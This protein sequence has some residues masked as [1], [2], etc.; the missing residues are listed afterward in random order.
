MLLPLLLCWLLL[1]RPHIFRVI[2]RRYRISQ[3]LP[4]PRRSQRKPE[5]V[6]QEVLRLA[7]PPGAGCRT[8]G[9]LFNRCYAHS[10]KMTVSKSYVHYTLCRH[11]Y[12]IEVM[13]RQLKHRP[14]RPVP[15]NRIWG[16]DLTGKGDVFGGIHQIL[17]VVDH[18]SRRLLMLDAV[19]HKNAWILLGQLFIAIGCFGKPRA[20]R[21]DNDAVF[22]SRVC[23][24]ACLPMFASS[25][26]FP[27]A[28]G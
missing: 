10:R 7:P 1:R 12:E 9:I 15:V 16:L 8:I 27:A 23:W 26:P 24:A 20:T 5:W 28:R 11:R 19:Q 18:G 17:G 22:K 4:S 25:S 13:R 14:P 3:S 2:R 6:K 21:T